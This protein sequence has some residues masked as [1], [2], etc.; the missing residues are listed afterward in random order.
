MPEPRRMRRFVADDG[1]EYDEIPAGLIRLR[2]EHGDPRPIPKPQPRAE[3]EQQVGELRE[4][5]AVEL[6]IEK[7]WA[8]R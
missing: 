4:M 2:L 8:R 6:T 3:V 7:G 1:T 5:T